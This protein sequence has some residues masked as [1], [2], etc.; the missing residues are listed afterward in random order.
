M[1]ASHIAVDWGTTRLR[2]HLVAADG[3][4]IASA[5]REM[6]VQAV[7]AG[8]FSDALRA[9]CGQWLAASPRIPLVL[10]GMVGSRN[11][12]TEVPYV[13]APCGMA[14]LAQGRTRL[15]M[16]G[17][18]A[19]IAPGVDTR[20]QDSG[21]YDVM[22][23][24]ETQVFGLG[25][26]DGIVC[27]PGTHSKWVRVQGGQIESFATFITGE[28]YAAMAGSFIAKLAEGP[29]EAHPGAILGEAS[30]MLPGGLSR[31]LFQ[32][33]TRVLAGDMGGAGVK[34]FLSALLVADEIAGARALF[35]INDPIH[36][37]AGDPQ[38]PVYAAALKTAG[39]GF[40]IHDPQAV[41]LAGLAKF[42]QMAE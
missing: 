19:L 26:D 5:A 10:A 23:G 37:V 27:L 7:P 17:H 31:A 4:I 9:C 11:G 20:W 6:G 16:D 42:M 13:S 12:W 41:F 40:C 14:Q 25:L 3:A 32:A 2:A 34:P 38:L 35:G 39:I 28:L 33:R 22:R 30:A 21:A 8:G 18:V 15:E 1:T 29:Q 24:E 36:L